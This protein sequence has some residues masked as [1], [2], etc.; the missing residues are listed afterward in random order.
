[1]DSLKCYYDVSWCRLE[2]KLWWKILS[3]IP[4]QQSLLNKIKEDIKFKHKVKLFPKN[5]NIKM[6]TTAPSLNNKKL[7]V[8]NIL[9][10]PW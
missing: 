1:M 4:K 3:K 10:D 9:Y 7:D 6:S 5:K 2:F 8:L